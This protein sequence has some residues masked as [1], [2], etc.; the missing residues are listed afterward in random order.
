[1]GDHNHRHA[2]RS[3]CLPVAR[4]SSIISCQVE[5]PTRG[6]DWAR[7][8]DRRQV[9]EGHWDQA[10]IDRQSRHDMLCL[11]HPH[12]G[13]IHPLTENNQLVNVPVLPQEWTNENLYY[14][15][16]SCSVQDHSYLV[17]LVGTL[18]THHHC[19]VKGEAKCFCERITEVVGTAFWKGDPIKFLIIYR[20]D[21]TSL[22]WD[23]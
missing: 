18:A 3:L 9:N 10:Q 7:M 23:R 5:Y 21:F 20:L 6:K 12:S 1:M 11:W 22:Q 4:K 2:V 15:E 19:H 16:S 17:S 14:F 8:T 13:F